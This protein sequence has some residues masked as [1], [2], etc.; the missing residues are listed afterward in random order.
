MRVYIN[1]QGSVQGP[2]DLNELQAFIAAGDMAADQTVCPE[3]SEAWIPASQILSQ[4][5]E[6]QVPPTAT[7]KRPRRKR[8]PVQFSLV[9]TLTVGVVALLLIGFAA[10]RLIW[11][12]AIPLRL[13]ASILNKHDRIELEGVS[14]SLAGGTTVRMFRYHHTDGNTSFIEDAG[15]RHSPI[16]EISSKRRFTIYELHASRAHLFLPLYTQDDDDAP[17]DSDRTGADLSVSKECPSPAAGEADS[18]QLFEIR[19]I[20][21]SDV[22]IEDR[23]S[24][25]RLD[26][27]TLHVDGLKVENDRLEIGELTLKSNAV[28]LHIPPSTTQLENGTVERTQIS[29]TGAIKPGV[30][31]QLAAA[32]DFHGAASIRSNHLENATFAI[33]DDQL[34]LEAQGDEALQTGSLAVDD[35]SLRH[36][37]PQL[38]IEHLTGSLHARMSAVD[39]MTMELNQGFFDLGTT[40]FNI[41]RKLLPR[42][43][44][45]GRIAFLLAQG[46]ATDLNCRIELLLQDGS[47]RE[48]A[49]SEITLQIESDPP[50]RKEEILASILFERPYRDLP[51]EQQQIVD[52]HGKIFTSHTY[53]RK[54]ED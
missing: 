45:E 54:T 13:A 49:T 48:G 32:I 17:S 42:L 34:T 1:R 16:K 3:G 41:E 14:G 36:Y 52:L 53:T 21:I 24:G 29:W 12:S 23:I 28:D 40:R 8:H 6:G 26:L 22:V 4:Q 37:F 43:D 51:T 39:G 19:T 9:T 44:D 18:L 47:K 7:V 31:E 33:F 15:F 20:D 2:Y 10:N 30:D 50:R 38:H 35:L 5:E 46:H 11:H 27:N 25:R